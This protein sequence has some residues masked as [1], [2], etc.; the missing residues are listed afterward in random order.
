MLIS[1]IQSNHEKSFHSRI[2]YINPPRPEQVLLCPNF[3]FQ[4]NEIAF[5]NTA[6]CKN[7]FNPFPVIHYYAYMLSIE[8][9]TF[10]PG[11]QHSC[12]QLSRLHLFSI[13]QSPSPNHTHTHTHTHT[14]FK[15]WTFCHSRP[16]I[17]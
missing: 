16:S 10:E 4:R 2:L 5:D 7:L 3:H 1:V 12:S 6:S 14:L 9:G 11:H 13:S 8:F 15:L 17:V